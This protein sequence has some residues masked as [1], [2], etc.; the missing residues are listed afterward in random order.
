MS[1]YK[2]EQAG[3]I[4]TK[5]FLTKPEMEKTPDKILF[6]VFYRRNERE[7][8]KIRENSLDSPEMG[9]ADCPI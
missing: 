3:G 2:N 7:F 6:V 5:F 8:D 4:M 1:I 9:R